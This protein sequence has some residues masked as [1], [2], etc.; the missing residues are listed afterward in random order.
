MFSKNIDNLWSL[1]R[2]FS[3]VLSPILVFSQGK[4]AQ[5]G[6]IKYNSIPCYKHKSLNVLKHGL[7]L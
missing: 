2:Y 1:P 7:I 4:K 3:L 5:Q 6:R